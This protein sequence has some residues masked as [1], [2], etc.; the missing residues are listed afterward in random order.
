MVFW[1]RVTSV[2]VHYWNVETFAEI[3][4]ALGNIEKTDADRAKIQ[5]SV[6]ADAPLQF[7]RRVGFPNGDTGMVTFIYEG[8]HR[9]CFTC[10]MLSHEEGTC[11]NLSPEQREEK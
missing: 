11:P 5:V 2:P 1:I 6:N 9:H 10:K 3:G 7:E 4:K 8:L